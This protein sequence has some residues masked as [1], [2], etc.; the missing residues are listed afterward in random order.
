MNIAKQVVE[1]VMG[2]GDI[3]QKKRSSEF[4][5]AR[6]IFVDLCIKYITE[7]PSEIGRFLK[8]DH[9]AIIHMRDTF[10]DQLFYNDFKVIVDEVRSR[11]EEFMIY[12]RTNEEQEAK[13]IEKGIN[14]LTEDQQEVLNH[15]IKSYIAICDLKNRN[16]E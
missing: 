15:V 14:G 1:Q 10:E 2:V 8:K 13:S 11:F 7:S 16:N 6:R 12:F 3:T 9:A 4:V 5:T